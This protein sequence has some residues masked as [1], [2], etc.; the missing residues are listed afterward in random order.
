MSE[1]LNPRDLLLKTLRWWW[2]LLV[3]LL[4]GGVAGYAFHIS[5]P[6]LYE[7]QATLTFSLDYAR[8]G[9]LTDAEED[10]AMGVAGALLGNID[11][12]EGLRAAAQAQGLLP[13]GFELGPNVIVER[14]S[15]RWVLRVRNPDPQ[16]ARKVAQLWLE[17]GT[18]ALK[19]ATLHTEQ[20]QVLRLQLVGLES[21]LRRMTVSDPTTAQCAWPSLPDLQREMAAL[22]QQITTETTA[23]QG[24]VAG[25]SYTVSDPPQVPAQ[26]VVFGRNN[27]M[28]AGGL[29]GFL[30]G[31]I[32]ISSGL[33]DRLSTRTKHAIE[34]DPRS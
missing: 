8:L 6:P 31:F 28:L 10:Q 4:L 17:M 27:L 7:S 5:Q 20:A 26:T 1:D 16:N 32:L 29:L 11:R 12:I 15:Y 9:R 13:P 21:C 24:M 33:L 19:D 25:L 23:A 18:N 22:G 2:L 34:T 3:G 30:A 14:K